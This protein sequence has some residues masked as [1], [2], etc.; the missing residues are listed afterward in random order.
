M[1]NKGFTVL[2]LA[3][4]VVLTVL[5]LG[6]VRAES[7]V[8]FTA[9][10][11]EGG[12]FSVNGGAYGTSATETSAD[13][14]FVLDVSPSAGWRFY[15]LLDGSGRLLGSSYP[16][17]SSYTVEL[18]SGPYQICFERITYPLTAGPDRADTGTVTGTGRYAVGDR[19]DLTAIP[20]PGY[21]FDCWKYDAGK[22]APDD[23]HRA[24]ATFTILPGYNGTSVTAVFTAMPTCP[25]TVTSDQ[26]GSVSGTG[27][28]YEGQTVTL[29]AAADP[30][31][32]FVR[33]DYDSA[34]VSLDSDTNTAAKCTMAPGFSGGTVRGVFE[35]LPTYPLTLIAQPAEGGSLTGAG[36]RYPGQVVDIAA[37]ASVGWDFDHWDYDSAQM[38]LD[39]DSKAQAKC[40]LTD[41]YAGAA[42][43]AVFTASPTY[44][45]TVAADPAAGGTVSGAGDYA[46]RDT[47]R[48]TAVPEPG[49]SFTGWEVT[50][51]G[52]SIGTDGTLT[53]P[54]NDVAV[55]AAFEVKYHW[56][57]L[58][59]E[60]DE[61]PV[62]GTAVQLD[63][64][65]A[66]MWSSAASKGKFFTADGADKFCYPDCPFAAPER[67]AFIGWKVQSTGAVVQPGDTGRAE[68]NALT[69]LWA[70]KITVIWRH[71]DGTELDRKVYLFGQ[72]EPTTDV[73]PKKATNDRYTYE[74][75]SWVL[76]QEDDFT[77]IY[78][79]LFAGTERPIYRV[80]D[81]ANSSWRH[82]SGKTV[83]LTVTRSF[84]NDKALDHFTGFKLGKK[85]L[86][87]DRDYTVARGGGVII[88]IKASAL[89]QFEVGIYD[90][91]VLFDDG[92][93]ITEMKILP[94]YDDQTGTGD[95]SHMFL[96]LGL[97]IL[98]CAGLA[99]LR[100]E[101]RRLRDS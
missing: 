88:T 87:R 81:G 66:A 40:T 97:T 27:S 22:V 38:T 65:G 85:T 1:R 19:A 23:D 94:A 24:D 54:E 49:Y 67:Y 79:P 10:P 84:D 62:S 52:V 5:P 35:K 11:A 82:R 51:G 60:A 20:A 99:V 46:P 100:V 47:V 37:A 25:L 98:G 36:D 86:K 13:G 2:L 77:R 55:T 95:N 34:Q 59:G 7:T 29:S 80:T 42:V 58:P 91:T 31:W 3:L 70:R 75:H 83:S 90:V 17:T 45:V 41:A 26:G 101:R 72:P 43:T 96:W 71:E 57:L 48:L 33:W 12:T 92:D 9:T 63:S 8:T 53:M 44:A 61:K 28:Y 15:G 64:A 68:D 30:G 74:F 4:L 16:S 76:D 21:V 50:S 69:A 89:D 73:V 14:R 93:A 78:I 18:G 32:V 56:R 6:A 39:D